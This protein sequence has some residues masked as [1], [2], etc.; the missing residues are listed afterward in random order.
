MESSVKIHTI[1]PILPYQEEDCPLS[2]SKYEK[3]KL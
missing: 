2:L 3:S 1:P